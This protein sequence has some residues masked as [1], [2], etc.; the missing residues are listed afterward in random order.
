M[1]L[2]R[3]SEH[4]I[5][6]WEPIK[7]GSWRFHQDQHIISD[8]WRHS[9]HCW[10]SGWNTWIPWPLTTAVKTNT[11]W[12]KNYFTDLMYVCPCIIYENDERYQLDATI[13]L[14]IWITLHVSGI[15]MPIFRSIRLYTFILLHMVFSTRCC[16]WGSE[17]P[18]C[19]LVHWCN[20]H[21]RTSATTP[22]AGHHME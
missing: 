6:F 5:L 15:C 7:R 9:K 3:I 2:L 20:L 18:V 10:K 13:Y 11:N 1:M 8:S 22:S 21:L 12:G 14:L 17:E 19:S 16:G 4:E